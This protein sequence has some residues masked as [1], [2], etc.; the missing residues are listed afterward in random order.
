MLFVRDFIETSHHSV[1][2]FII[3]LAPNPDDYVLAD[4]VV[5]FMGFDVPQKYHYLV[6]NHYRLMY[7]EELDRFSIFL[8]CL[9]EVEL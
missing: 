6:I 3:A 4:Y 1:Y 9:C 2:E 8:Y 5:S 7:N